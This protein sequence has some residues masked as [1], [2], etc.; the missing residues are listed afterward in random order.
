M[1]KDEVKAAVVEASA[2][3]ANAGDTGRLTIDE[4]I[5][6]VFGSYRHC[7]GISHKLDHTSLWEMFVISD[8][9]DIP[10][11]VGSYNYMIGAPK[12]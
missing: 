9:G 4:I 1:V 2:L 7:V 6:S 8:L 11:P 3:I 12:K 10:N 5:M